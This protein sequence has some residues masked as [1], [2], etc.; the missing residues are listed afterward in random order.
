VLAAAVTADVS[1]VLAEVT[2]NDGAVPD[3]PAATKTGTQQYGDT[4]DN[5]DAWT[6]GYTPQ[7]AAVVWVGRAEPG[8]I[9]EASG[10]PIQGDGLP[11]R[12]WRGFLTAALAG[13]PA[14]PLPPPANLGSDNAGDA[15]PGFE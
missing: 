7:L 12:M 1:T 10:R 15:R 11:A 13:Q 9:R 4:D 3:R 8:P 2:D 5:S 14:A 6:A